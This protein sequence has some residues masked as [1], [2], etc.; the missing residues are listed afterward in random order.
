MH[1]AKTMI[2]VSLMCASTQLMAQQAPT[3]S[4]P[5]TGPSDRTVKLARLAGLKVQTV[6]GVTQFCWETKQ[7]G[8]A[9]KTRT[10]TDEEGLKKM[11]ADQSFIQDDVHRATNGSCIGTQACGLGR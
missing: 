6:K 2:L 8:T 11:L 10:C 9:F 5:D 1:A 7:L 3:D 4:K